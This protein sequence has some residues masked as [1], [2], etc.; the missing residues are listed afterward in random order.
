[1]A[2]YSRAYST[3]S[4]VSEREHAAKERRAMAALKKDVADYSRKQAHNLTRAPLSRLTVRQ[5]V[6]EGAK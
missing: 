4:G 6:R 3:K 5:I 2:T 1:M